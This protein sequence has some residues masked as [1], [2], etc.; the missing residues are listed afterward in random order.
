MNIA[1]VRVSYK[2]KQAIKQPK[3]WIEV[4]NKW[5]SRELTGTKAMELLRLKRSTFYKLIKDYEGK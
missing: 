4:Y 5:K 2:G 3:N 1:Y